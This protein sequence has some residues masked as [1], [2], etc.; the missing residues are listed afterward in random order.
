LYFEKF[1]EIESV[2]LFTFF[3]Y[4]IFYLNYS[5]MHVFAIDIARSRCVLV[6]VF[7]LLFF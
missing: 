4:Y 3:I 5:Y 7:V 1:I 2:Y 6:L